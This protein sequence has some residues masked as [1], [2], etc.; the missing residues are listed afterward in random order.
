MEYSLAVFQRF[1]KKS[2]TNSSLSQHH[3]KRRSNSTQQ[4]MVVASMQ[5]FWQEKS[6]LQ[7]QAVFQI[8][9]FS[10]KAFWN[11]YFNSF[12][13]AYANT[14]FSHTHTHT[15]TQSIKNVEEKQARGQPNCTSLHEIIV[16]SLHHCNAS[17][18]QGILQTAVFTAWQ[19]R[20]PFQWW[21]VLKGSLWNV[22]MIPGAFHTWVQ[23]CL[24]AYIPVH[25]ELEV[26]AIKAT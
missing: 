18:R 19:P 3:S 16:Q 13:L 17:R 9:Y 21:L 11:L 25:T 5:L 14:Q 8:I 1:T 23:Q 2:S 24:N 7:T 10:R 22:D 20:S 6:K 15:R 4:I 12:K 26:P